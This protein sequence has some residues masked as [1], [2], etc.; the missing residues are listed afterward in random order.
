MN[1]PIPQKSQDKLR[2]IHSGQAIIKYWCQESNSFETEHLDIKLSLTDKILIERYSVFPGIEVSYNYFFTESFSHHHAHMPTIMEVNHCRYG[3]IGWEMEENLNLYLGEGDFSFHMKDNCAKSFLSCP[4]HYYEGVSFSLDFSELEKNIPDILKESGI[5]ILQ[6]LNTY[7]DTHTITAIQKD[8]YNDYSFN[9]LYD[10]SDE[11]IIPY[12]KL[13]VQEFIL[14]LSKF[15]FHNTSL[16]RPCE[17][18]QVTI[19]KEIHSF[20]TTNLNTRYTIEYLSK[21]YLMNSSTLKTT[22]KSVY[23]MPIASYMKQ[24]RINKAMQLLRETNKTI[25]EISSE[26]GYESQSKFTS[27]FKKIIGVLPTTYRKN[28]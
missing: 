22:F 24:Y 26:I 7:G 15:K 28:I 20:L 1:I 23:G 10:L 18:E 27:T 17:T 25:A 13:K 4:L 9:G 12:L 21:K 5:N 19:I 6:L 2:L 3:R 14:F 8:Y 11:L 16:L